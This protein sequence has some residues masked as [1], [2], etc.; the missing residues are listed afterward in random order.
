MAILVI[1]IFIEVELF[2]EGLK[3]HLPQN[4]LY[5]SYSLASN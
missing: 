2:I 1:S 4:V 3:M 5:F